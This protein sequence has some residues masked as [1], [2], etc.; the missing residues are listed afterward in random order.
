MDEK[1]QALFEEKLKDL[2][3]L[4]KKKKGVLEDA[5]IHDF[6]SGLTLGEEQYDRVLETMEQNGIELLKIHEE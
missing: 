4:G 5:E 1:E 3:E 2:V 6:F